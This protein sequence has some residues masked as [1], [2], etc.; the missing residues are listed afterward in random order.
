MLDANVMCELQLKT[1][2]EHKCLTFT[3][4]FIL[5]KAYISMQCD[6]VWTVPVVNFDC[7]TNK[8]QLRKKGRS[9]YLVTSCSFIHFQMGSFLLGRLFAL[10]RQKRPPLKL[11]TTPKY[12][13]SLN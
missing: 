2:D 8:S 11:V 10:K 3:I 13:Y 1:P 4:A 5:T 12:N 7:C 6:Y 9:I